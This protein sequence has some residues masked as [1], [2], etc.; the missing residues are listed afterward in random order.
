MQNIIAVLFANESEGFQAITEL[1]QLPV[2]EKNALLQMGLVK[3]EGDKLSLCDGFDAGIITESGAALG[4][5]MGGLVGILG[6][7]LGV[8]LMGSYGA[9][10]GSIAG[11]AAT[12]D[13]TLLLEKVAGKLVDGEVALIALADETDEEELNRRLSKFQVEIARFDAAEIAEEVE[14]AERLQLEDSRLALQD[15]V[16]ARKEDHKAAI[17]DKQKKLA[18]DFVSYREQKQLAAEARFDRVYGEKS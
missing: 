17:E 8:L 18:E 4:G 13:S 5:L 9:L 2:T 11:S 3:R 14:E 7:P 16:K 10:T 1:R 6:G 15:L 12:L